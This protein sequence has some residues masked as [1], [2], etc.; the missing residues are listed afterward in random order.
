M[1]GNYLSI[2]NVT[3]RTGGRGAAQRELLPVINPA[4]SFG[5]KS[6]SFCDEPFF[7]SIG[8]LMAFVQS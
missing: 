4:L 2:Q 5:K 3:M 8:N 7:A 6:R 1:G